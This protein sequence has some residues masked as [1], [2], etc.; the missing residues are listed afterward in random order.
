MTG[1]VMTRRVSNSFNAE[2]AQFY[3]P[4]GGKRDPEA[5]GAFAMPGGGAGMNPGGG[6]GKLILQV[7]GREKRSDWLM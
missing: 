3:E 1:K 6:G 7:G 5:W 2:T 4:S